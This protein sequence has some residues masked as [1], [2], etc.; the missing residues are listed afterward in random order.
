MHPSFLD[1]EHARQTTSLALSRAILRNPT[2]LPPQVA[3]AEHCMLDRL[4]RQ[5]VNKPEIYASY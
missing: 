4:Q 5:H 2:Q 1:A 3:R